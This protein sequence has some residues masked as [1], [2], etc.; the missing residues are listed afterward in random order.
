MVGDGRE[1]GGVERG[2]RRKGRRRVMDAGTALDPGTFM[3][4]LGGG[5][6]NDAQAPTPRSSGINV[7]K[8]SLLFSVLCLE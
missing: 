8:T 2:R 6:G 3:S 5:V 1:G 4:L 7:V